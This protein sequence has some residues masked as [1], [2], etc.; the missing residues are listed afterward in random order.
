MR[1][2][3]FAPGPTE[4][5]PVV[6]AELRAMADEGYLSESHRSG[7]VRREVTR[8]GEALRALLRIPDAYRVLLVG[9]ATEAMERIVEGVGPSRSHHLVQGA[10]G[11]RFRD[12]ARNAGVAVQDAEVADGMSFRAQDMAFAADTGLVAMTQNETS[13]GARIPPGELRALAASA[14]EAG[15]LVA[16]D[17]VSGW[18]SEA[19]DP[20][21]VDAGFFSVQKGFGLPPGLGVIVASP[22]LVER[23]RERLGRGDRVGGWMHIPALADAADRNETVATPNTLAIRLLACVAEAY[24]AQGGQEALAE[25]V[26]QGFERWWTAIDALDALGTPGGV[27]LT[28]FVSDLE[29]RSRTVAV[30]AVDGADRIREGLRARG[31]VVG[32]GYGPWKGRHL[33]VAHFP[34]QTPEMQAR[35]LDALADEVAAT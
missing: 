14:R 20:A 7:P 17:L 2:L 30:V 1:P 12:V 11:R 13:T 21:W 22:A 5:H 9:S 4:L 25:R 16:V 18:P 29:L 32:D 23:A 8:L 35:L 26:E 3:S 34:V 6:R 33:R 24:L 10:F 27:R 15:A 19:V 28:P 31:L